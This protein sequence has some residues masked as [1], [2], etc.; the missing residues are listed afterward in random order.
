MMRPRDH[1]SICHIALK[2]MP[3]GGGV[4]MYT[5]QVGSRL[6]ARGHR[7]IVYVMKHYGD[8]PAR[9]RGMEI[10]ALPTIRTKSLE[11]PVVSALATVEQLIRRE[12]DLVHLH[13]FGPGML[14][15]L[16]RL[17]GVPTVVQGH[18]LEWKRA[19]WGTAARL[20]L[21]VTERV[22]VRFADEV[23]VVSR[24]LQQYIARRYHRRS[25]YIPTGINPAEPAEADWIV[26][27]GLQPGRFILF[28]SRLVPEKGAHLLIRAFRKLDTPVKLVIAGDA[29][30][31]QAYKAH[32]REL[33][34]DDERIFFAGFVTATP[35]RELLTH[36]LLYVQPS[37][38][39]GLSI[40]LL[41][42]MSY[43]RPCLVSDIPE[44]LEAI[45]ANG[46]TF[47]NGDE[48]DLAEKLSTLLGRAEALAQMGERARRHVLANYSWDTIALQMESLY[49][50][51]L[52]RR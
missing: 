44:N 41:E 49:R 39:E 11:K 29:E 16:T 9:Y 30:H 45:D 2:G 28:M 14:A 24:T 5:E 21:K 37:R 36:C 52:S 4:E 22:S 43:G 31:E 1:F 34:G 38:L 19:R 6:A 33:A 48:V 12:C 17:G 27:Q 23:T 18:G 50:R 20:V 26:R 3:L 46:F 15:M 25:V 10:R 47:R 8:V 51:V 32:L 42:A 40:A 7:V 13:A 35:L